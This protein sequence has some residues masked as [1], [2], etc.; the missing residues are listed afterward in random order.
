MSEQIKNYWYAHNCC[1]SIS[2]T[3]CYSNNFDS[4][5]QKKTPADQVL[6]LQ[7]NER[8]HARVK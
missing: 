6:N 8:G 4:F 2:L 1:K 5:L 3:K 7:Q